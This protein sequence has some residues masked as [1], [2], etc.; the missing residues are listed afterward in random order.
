MVAEP[1]QSTENTQ[2]QEQD[3]GEDTGDGDRDRD[4]LM[5]RDE[6]R[7][8]KRTGWGNTYNRS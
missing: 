1:G 6:W 2:Q 3:L 7:D 8:M 4:S 5:A